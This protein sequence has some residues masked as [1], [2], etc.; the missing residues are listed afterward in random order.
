MALISENLSQRLSDRTQC[1]GEAEV[2]TP[3]PI[4]SVL[5]GTDALDDR[6]GFDGRG[7]R[8]IAFAIV[9]AVPLWA[10]IA[11]AAISIFNAVFRN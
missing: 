6:C 5:Y 1:G 11:W 3:P 8:G 2:A 4:S 9:L 10:V 7:F